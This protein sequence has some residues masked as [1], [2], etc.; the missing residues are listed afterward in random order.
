MV[1][2][3]VEELRGSVTKNNFKRQRFEIRNKRAMYSG[4]SFARDLKSQKAIMR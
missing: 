1:K 2:T 4:T 3:R